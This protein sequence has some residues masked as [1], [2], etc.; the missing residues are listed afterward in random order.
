ML[1]TTK[2][3]P[4]K[5]VFQ[6]FQVLTILIVVIYLYY[7]IHCVKKSSIAFSWSQDSSAISSQANTSDQFE[8]IL[9]SLRWG[10][11]DKK[12]W[13]VLESLSRTHFRLK[14]SCD[15]RILRPR[16]YT[17]G[18]FWVLEN[19]IAAERKDVKC[20]QSVTYTTHTDYTFLS[21]LIP[22]VERWMAPV[23]VALFTPGHDLQH[24]KDAIFY[25]R[26]CLGNQRQ[27]NLIKELVSFHLYFSASH[28]PPTNVSRIIEKPECHTNR[29][30]TTLS[31]G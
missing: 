21:N 11:D 9:E 28:M 23:S 26:Y 8:N 22:V 31:L 2:L 10:P 12:S 14:I 5:T 18:S 25:L 17:R 13:I 6:V 24:T 29:S 20:F 3:W 27:M 7:V 30:L 19:Y 15:D 16:I 1:R 4:L